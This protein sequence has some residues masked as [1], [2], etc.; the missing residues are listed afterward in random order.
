MTH[1]S[2]GASSSLSDAFTAVLAWRTGEVC[3]ERFGSIERTVA[4]GLASRY[5]GGPR[6]RCEQ[7][8]RP[9]HDR[10]LWPTS[11]KPETNGCA[12]KFI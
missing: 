6:F 8:E 5:N 1:I 4:D 2:S 9:P 12:E 3:S 7:V 10:P 11:T